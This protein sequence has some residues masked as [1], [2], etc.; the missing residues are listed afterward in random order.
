VTAMADLREIYRTLSVLE[1]EGVAGGP[2]D[3]PE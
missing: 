2:D 1:R 3:V